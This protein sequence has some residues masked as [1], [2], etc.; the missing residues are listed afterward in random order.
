MVK[1]DKVK[2]LVSRSGVP[3]GTVVTVDGDKDGNIIHGLV[4]PD[5]IAMKVTN[6]SMYYAPS[7]VEKCK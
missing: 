1:G 6:G 2:T 4:N 5:W 7:E 3:A